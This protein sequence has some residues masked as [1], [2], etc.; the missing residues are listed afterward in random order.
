MFTSYG[1]EHWGFILYGLG[2]PL[3]CINILKYPQ[4]GFLSN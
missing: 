1:K 2:A 4:N 3:G